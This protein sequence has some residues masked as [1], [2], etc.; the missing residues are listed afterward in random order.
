M[1]FSLFQSFTY[2]PDTLVNVWTKKTKKTNKQ[3]NNINNK[4]TTPPRMRTIMCLNLF[5]STQSSQK[6]EIFSQVKIYLAAVGNNAGLTADILWLLICRHQRQ[7]W[8]R[9]SI[10]DWVKLIAFI[11][12]LCAGKCI[13][14]NSNDW[15]SKHTEE[16]EKKELEKKVK[17]ENQRWAKRERRGGM[18]KI[19][20]IREKT[21]IIIRMKEING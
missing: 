7:K 19:T 2:K 5:N 12:S 15:Y 13:R 8:I 11:N 20:Y 18:E 21:W 6:M 10:I 3:T 16:K 9:L 1:A 14:L 17:H 4:S